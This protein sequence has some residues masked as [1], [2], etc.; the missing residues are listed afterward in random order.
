VIELPVLQA[1]A[2]GSNSPLTSSLG[3]MPRLFG[4]TY[5]ARNRMNMLFGARIESGISGAFAQKLGIE[6]FEAR[7]RGPILSHAS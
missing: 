5:S 1:T 4:S 3:V 6:A 7:V 2:A